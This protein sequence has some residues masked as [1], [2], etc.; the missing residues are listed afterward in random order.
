MTTGG[1]G[2]LLFNDEREARLAKHITTNG[3][4]TPSM[5]LLS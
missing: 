2:A 5:D 3:S 4:A 1:G